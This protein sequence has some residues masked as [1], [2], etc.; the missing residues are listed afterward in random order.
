MK[1]AIMMM[2]A[3]AAIAAN[4]KTVVPYPTIAD[5]VYT[6]AKQTADVPVSDKYTVQLN[7]GGTEAKEYKVYLSLTDS[8]NYQWPDT[9]NQVSSVSWYI[10]KAT[11]NAWTTAPAVTDWKYGETQP[12]LTGASKYGAVGYVYNGTQADGTPIVNAPSVTK[13]G[14]YTVTFTVAETDSYNGLTESIPFMIAKGTVDI[15]GGGS[16]GAGNVTVDAHGWSGVYDG[17]EHRI[18]LE[19]SGE[20]AASFAKSF[21]MAEAGPYDSEN[22]GFAEIGSHKVWYVLESDFY[23]SVTGNATVAISK[24]EVDLPTISPKVY[25]GSKQTAD[26]PASDK[27][28]VKLNGGGTDVGTYQ[29]YLELADDT[30]CKW[31]GSDEKIVS[32]PFEI[33]ADGNEWIV[34]PQIEGWQYGATPSIPVAEAKY[35][36][37]TVVYS[38]DTDAGDHIE[39]AISV[40]KA[41]SYTAKFRVAASAKGSYPALSRDIAFTVTKGT[42]DIGGGGTGGAKLEVNGWNGQYDGLPHSIT[43]AMTGDDSTTF[44]YRYALEETGVYSAVNPQF[45]EVTNQTVWCEISSPDYQSVKVHAD[46]VITPVASSAA[47]LK[48]EIGW[49]YLKASGTYFAQIKVTCTNGFDAGVSDL[50][51]RFADR[52]DGAD[53]VASLWSTLSRAANANEET[54]GG[55]TYRYVELD[56]AKLTAQDVAAVYGVSNLAA[57]TIP[58]AERTIEMYVMKRL[59]PETGNAGAAKVGDFVGY[60][61]WKSGG[62]S[63]SIPLVAGEISQAKFAALSALSAPLSI[64]SLNT[65]LAVGSVVAEGSSPYC[66]LVRFSVGPDTITGQVEVGVTDGASDMKGALGGNARVTL[67]GKKNLAGG[68]FAELGTVE[69]AADGTFTA[70]IPEGYS[71]FRLRLE[72]T[73]AIR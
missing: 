41:G 11:D 73:E 61:S 24:M 9:D 26:V 37:V 52:Y 35:G 21:A 51:F 66:K 25:N 59:V 65:S 16:G 53:R 23:Q 32:V 71:F 39:D 5:K 42:I 2:C 70:A 44:D 63:H 33:T 36:E 18:T 72:I 46:V 67:L 6:G 22:P 14:T 57:A 34:E 27:Y 50:K 47:L 54:I 10:T 29:V 68:D 64:K 7:S 49:A 30:H 20:D 15:A 55:E 48:A 38:G 40:S 1:S 8:D 62:E 19:L 28:T 4:A 43:V 3:F 17:A 45:T 12:P 69:S 56:A 31:A 58:V 13:P 60:L